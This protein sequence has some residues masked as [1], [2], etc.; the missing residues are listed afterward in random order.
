M[1]F[2]IIINRHNNWQ[3]E[4]VQHTIAQETAENNYPVEL[5]APPT[6][7]INNVSSVCCHAASTIAECHSLLTWQLGLRY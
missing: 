3:Q 1:I 4:M 5:N 2:A 7:S 6:F